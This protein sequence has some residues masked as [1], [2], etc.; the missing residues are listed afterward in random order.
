MRKKNGNG[1]NDCV[2]GKFCKRKM[3]DV[4]VQNFTFAK[5]SRMWHTSQRKFFIIIVRAREELSS[6]IDDDGE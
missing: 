5:E 6:C 2:F 4:D 1:N 3:G